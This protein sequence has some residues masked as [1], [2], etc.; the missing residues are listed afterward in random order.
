M[1]GLGWEAAAVVVG[2]VAT[3]TTEGAVGGEAWRLHVGRI[4]QHGGR[5]YGPAGTS[6]GGWRWRL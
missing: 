2:W 6:G 5:A 4:P 1:V 3:C